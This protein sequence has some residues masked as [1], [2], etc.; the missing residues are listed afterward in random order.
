MALTGFADNETEHA[1]L[2]VGLLALLGAGIG[3]TAV[4]NK[5]HRNEFDFLQDQIDDNRL[6]LMETLPGYDVAYSDRLMLRREAQPMDYVRRAIST[7]K[8][9]FAR[10]MANSRAAQAEHYAL[11]S[12]E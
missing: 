3:Y 5:R 8:D 4:H 7:S 2:A 6:A 10:R 1:V 12:D 11:S 9:R